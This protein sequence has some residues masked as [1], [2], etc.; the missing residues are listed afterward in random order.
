[1]NFQEKLFLK[2]VG[3][4]LKAKFWLPGL[5]IQT[6]RIFKLYIKEHEECL[7]QTKKD[8]RKVNI[9]LRLTE[10]IFKNSCL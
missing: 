7:S 3:R 4:S 10:D 2:K 6:E 9:N 5:L 1:M 8:D